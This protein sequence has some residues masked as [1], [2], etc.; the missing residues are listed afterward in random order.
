MG[1]VAEVKM[2]YCCKCGHLLKEDDRFCSGCGTASDSAAAHPI[3][4]PVLTPTITK[5]VI[6]TPKRG[7]WLALKT[8]IMAFVVYLVG[9]VSL[10]STSDKRVLPTWIAF[11][12]GGGAIYVIA[13]LRTWKQHN[14][15]VTAAATGWI[16]AVFMAMICLSGLL[17]TVGGPSSSTSNISGAAS[18]DTLSGVE[19][20]DI[21]MRDTKLDF[22]WSKGGFDSFMM[23]DFTITNPTQYRFKDVEIKCTHFAPSGTEIDS[24]TRTIYE[25]FEPLS[26]KKIWQMNMGFI[27]SQAASSGCKITNLTVLQRVLDAKSPI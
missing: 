22:S 14:E 16:V 17:G 10:H 27:H 26:T 2:A 1:N 19:P 9:A 11:A 25:T 5:V 6:V 21:L 24:N 12:F 13:R 18:S 4:S 15:P 7:G 20:K 23:A 8:L 3:A